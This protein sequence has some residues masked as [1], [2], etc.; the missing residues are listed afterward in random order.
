M[1]LLCVLFIILHVM[2]EPAIADRQTD[3][4]LW[5]GGF[6]RFD[7]HRGLDYSVEYQVRLD[8][9]ARS[10]NS[11]F[12]EFLGHKQVSED[13]ELNGGSRFTIRP[14]HDEHRLYF[15]GFWDVRSYR[16]HPS[17]DYQNRFK[18]LLQL[19]YQYDFDVKLDDRL[20]DSQSLRYILTAAKP[21]TQKVTPFLI[22][23]VLT[24]WNSAHDFGVDKIRL[25]GGLALKISEESLMRFTYMLEEN[26]FIDPIKRT[27]IFWVRYEMRW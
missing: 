18:L 24:T 11:H 21:V 7:G 16:S 23:G 25:G 9:D 19:G 12:M 4:A 15:G 27:N 5:S 20:M 22:G 14:D 3:G 2:S 8:E 26:R 10:L 13:L 17:K 1:W 6:F